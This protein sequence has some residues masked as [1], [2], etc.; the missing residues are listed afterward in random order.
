MFLIS[1][2]F[3]EINHK[4]EYP[5]RYR[6]NFL[7]GTNRQILTP[8]RYDEHPSLFKRGVPPGSR[9]LSEMNGK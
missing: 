7:G 5:K 9:I 4:I 6:D 8:E 1:F 3:L 2:F